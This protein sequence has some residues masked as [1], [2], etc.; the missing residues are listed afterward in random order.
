MDE[1]LVDAR[2]VEIGASDPAPGGPVEVLAIDCHAHS[3]DL[4]DP[5]DEALVD[6]RGRAMIASDRPDL[7]VVPVEVR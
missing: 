1:L 3:I 4:R 7:R 6:L 5:R 2:A